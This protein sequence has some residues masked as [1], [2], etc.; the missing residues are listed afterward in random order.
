MALLDFTP[1]TRLKNLKVFDYKNINRAGYSI[2][3]NNGYTNPTWTIM[4][5]TLR[6]A[7][8]LIK[9]SKF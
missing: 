9:I 2:F 3:S 5:L 1:L 4:T 8:R 6:F 7:K